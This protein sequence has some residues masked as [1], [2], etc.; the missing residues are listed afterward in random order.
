MFILDL[1]AVGNHTV[2]H[3]HRT[4]YQY[5]TDPFSWCSPRVQHINNIGSIINIQML[6]I[7]NK[8]GRYNPAAGPLQN[9][10]LAPA[11]P[12][13]DSRPLA[14]VPCH[15]TAH[16]QCV[17]YILCPPPCW[18]TSTSSS[19]NNSPCH[20]SFQST[21]TYKTTNVFEFPTLPTVS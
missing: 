16:A 13:E 8:G 11:A 1:K 20:C 15:K 12:V 4:S 18:S 9:M 21:L 17:F 5:T 6:E 10:A 7:K 19:I 14:G 3:I 2:A